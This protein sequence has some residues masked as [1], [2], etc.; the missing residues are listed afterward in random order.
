MKS[1]YNSI[2]WFLN[3]LVVI[4]KCPA[5]IH[6]K[7][8]TRQLFAIFLFYSALIA[9]KLNEKRMTQTPA[10]SGLMQ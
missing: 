4:I 7:K 5:R 10:R 3:A 2:H 8:W 1:R 6:A 9:H